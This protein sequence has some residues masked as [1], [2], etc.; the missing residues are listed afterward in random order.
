MCLADCRD[1]VYPFSMEIYNR[2]EFCDDRHDNTNDCMKISDGLLTND[3]NDVIYVIGVNHAKTNMSSYASI[4]VYDADYF[5]GVDGI[6]DEIMD[7]SVW[8]YIS[9]ITTLKTYQETVLPYLYIIE[10]R[11]SCQPNK[12]TCLEV[13]S[14][15][16]DTIT[17]G[18]IPLK[19][20]VVLIERMYNHPQT[21][22]GPDQSEVVLPIIIHMRYKGN[23][24][25]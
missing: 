8:N 12:T 10:I 21:H 22:V 1:T 25:L 2:A 19:D 16:T 13:S 7:N 18:F 17:T 23:V 14:L 15:A 20:I 4:S 3:E 9:P 11:R 5:W 6:G 24:L